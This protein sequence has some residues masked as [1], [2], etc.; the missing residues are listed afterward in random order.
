MRHH[1]TRHWKEPQGPKRVSVQEEMGRLESSYRKELEV[2][3]DDRQEPVHGC[4]GAEAR[5]DLEWWVN[6][7]SKAQDK[8]FLP[9]TPDLEIYTDASLSGWGACCNEVITRGTWTLSD[10][11]KHINEL[12][13][14]AALFALQVFAAVSKKISLRFFMDN[15]TAVAYIKHGGGSRSQAL[16]EISTQLT[17]WCEDRSISLE[18]V[19]LADKL[20]S[21]AD[22]ESRAGM[23]SGNWKLDPLVFN[24]IQDLWP[25][26]V[27][28]FATPWNVQRP[29][30]ISWHPQ[31]GAMAKNAFSVN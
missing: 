16:T 5:K 12:E 7:L 2:K 25:S 11:R 23:D 28:A 22:A 31:P 17:T 18:V 30:F 8:V 1:R 20:N 9:N 14:L 13:L 24:R 29:S 3:G 10:S 4:E 6:N 26:A 19:H 27:D 21:I 15:S